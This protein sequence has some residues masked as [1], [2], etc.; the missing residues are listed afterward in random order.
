[1]VRLIGAYPEDFDGNSFVTAKVRHF[2]G[3][4]SETVGYLILSCTNADCPPVC[5]TLQTGLSRVH[6]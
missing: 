2:G 3:C 1:M 6:P 4:G 5:G